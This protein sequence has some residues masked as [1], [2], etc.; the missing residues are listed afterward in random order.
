M[1][2]AKVTY[3]RDVLI[4]DLSKNL[5]VSTQDAISKAKLIADSYNSARQ[6][7]SNDEEAKKMLIKDSKSVFGVQIDKQ[8]LETALTYVRQFEGNIA[9]ENYVAKEREANKS[10]G[11]LLE[12]KITSSK[13]VADTPFSN[14]RDGTYDS[15][16]S[17]YQWSNKGRAFGSTAEAVYLGSGLGFLQKY[18]DMIPAP[19]DFVKSFMRSI[20]QTRRKVIYT[21]VGIGIVG[22][23]LSSY[24]EGLTQNQIYSYW[25]GDSKAK[26]EQV[27]QPESK[28]AQIP[29][30]EEAVKAEEKKP[31]SEVKKDTKDEDVSKKAADHSTYK[32]IFKQK[33]ENPETWFS[34]QPYKIELKEEGTKYFVGVTLK[35][36]YSKDKLFGSIKIGDKWHYG[37]TFDRQMLIPATKEQYESLRTG[38]F[39]PQQKMYQA[40]DVAKILNIYASVNPGK[41]AANVVKPQEMAEKPHVQEVEVPRIAE[42]PTTKIPFEPE[43]LTQTLT[44]K[45]SG[46]VMSTEKSSSYKGKIPFEPEHLTIQDSLR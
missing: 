24:R 18:W 29:K 10:Q 19:K 5:G 28:E 31:S 41:K 1:A 36:S 43:H 46:E 38:K 7:V 20:Q 27:I 37:L 40:D 2:E 15:S 44:E 22:V 16:N 4:G 30:L 8:I 42:K 35:T 9:S 13:T 21:A 45:V 3:T 23:G 34:L 6:Y 32:W 14:S 11:K 26:V 39:K 33:G 12:E 17:P 25:V